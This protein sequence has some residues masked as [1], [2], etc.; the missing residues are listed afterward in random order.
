MAP[1]RYRFLRRP[2]WIWARGYKTFT[3]LSS[4]KHKIFHAHKYIIPR[5][6]AFLGSDKPRLLFFLLIN[7]K[8][9]IDIRQNK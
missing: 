9:A 6:L 2:S 4:A 7:V 5:N 8:N 3:M 1:I